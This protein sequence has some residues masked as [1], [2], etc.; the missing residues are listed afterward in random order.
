MNTKS[1]RIPA[2]AELV[3]AVAEFLE[4]ELLPSLEGNRQFNTRVSINALRIVQRQL[5]RPA[6]ESVLAGLKD[7][8]GSAADSDDLDALLTKLAEHIRSGNIDENDPAL[9]AV[10]RLHT[11]ERLAVDNPKYSSYG[12]ALGRK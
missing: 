4:K 2:A 7:L 11:L 9:L 3:E 5:A 1:T 8:L 10:L 6:A 12:A